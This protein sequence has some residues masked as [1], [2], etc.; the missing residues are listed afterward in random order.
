MPIKNQLFLAL[1]AVAFIPTLL[2]VLSIYFH[3]RQETDLISRPDA[4]QNLPR[5]T[6][7]N[8]QLNQYLVFSGLVSLCLTAVIVPLT[9]WSISSKISTLDKKYRY[10]R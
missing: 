7:I 8:E 1:A 3:V 4:Y 9:S 2:F 5:L 10:Y 6:R